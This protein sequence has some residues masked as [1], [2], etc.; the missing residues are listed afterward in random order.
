MR[1]H[2][3]W[4]VF[5]TAAWPAAAA[6]RKFE[7]NQFPVGQTPPGFRSLVTGEGKPGDWQVLLDSV[8]SQMPTLTP[9]AVSNAK[10]PVIAQLA[11][12]KTDEHFSL[13]VFDGDSYGDFTL[14]TQFKVV[15]GTAEQMAGVAFRIQD[16]KN[17]YVVR[18]SALG[19]NFRFYKFVNG[20]RS[21]S[22]GPDVAITKNEWHELKVQCQGNQIICWLDGK[23]LIPPLTDNSFSSGKV[24]LWTKSDAVSY[25]ADTT[26]SY[27]PR[28]PM[29]QTV[30][31]DVLTT[32]SRLRGLKIV[33]PKKEGDA[34]SMIVMD[35]KDEAN[36][37]D[38]G[39][40]VHQK[41]YT[42]GTVF[43]AKGKE[44]VFVVMPLRDRN[45]DTIGA[46]E[47]TMESFIGQT[48]QNAL[49]R[50]MPIVKAI[51]ARIQTAKE[52][53]P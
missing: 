18:A 41:A 19:N 37:G 7:L 44:N 16:E 50:A 33:A 23:G 27:T 26:I 8:P 21:T 20:I 38:P 13:L 15:S 30:A 32:Y 25:F 28:V 4:L 45:G 47:L 22:I 36:L 29:A 48:E 9:N 31:H 17:Y 5:L 10:R 51:Q 1:I 3:L 52:L 35:C 39:E 11:Q 24:G 6:E 49:A 46:V 2:I 14:T 34:A 12:D 42:Q 40:E 53:T 43:Y